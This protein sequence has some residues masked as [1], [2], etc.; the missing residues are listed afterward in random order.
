M[1]FE[2]ISITCKDGQTTLNSNLVKRYSPIEIETTDFSDN[3]VYIIKMLDSILKF[4]DQYFPEG[5]RISIIYKFTIEN[6]DHLADIA[7]L[8]K[9]QE[10]MNFY[11]KV[12]NSVFNLS[13]CIFMSINEAITKYRIDHQNVFELIRLF[14]MEKK[15]DAQYRR[16]HKSWFKTKI[17]IEMRKQIEEYARLN[18]N[19]RKFE[20]FGRLHELPND[21]V[22]HFIEEY[23]G[24]VKYCI[25][26]ANSL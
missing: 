7:E 12:P 10:K 25:E 13:H 22:M 9:V 8:L 24:Y 11:E 23:N 21:I 26:F 16:I 5:P 3:R 6:M 1:S 4:Y 19:D 14:F 20:N 18:T 2:Q 17:I 15:D